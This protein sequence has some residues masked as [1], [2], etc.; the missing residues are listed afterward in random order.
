MLRG[1][2]G[3]R[4][5]R[6]GHEDVVEH[7]RRQI[8]VGEVAVVLRLLLAA[9]AEG[10]PVVLVP[11]AGLLH[12]ASAGVENRG[13]PC[14]L[15]RDGFLD[16]AERVDVLQLDARAELRLAQGADAHVRVAP[17]ASLLEVAVVDADEDEDVAQHTQVLRGF[18]RAAQIGLA[19]DLD[20]RY[21]GAVE[22]DHARVPAV[23][24]LACVLL[25]V[26][27]RDADGADGRPP[28]SMSRCP[29]SL[30]GSSYWLIWYPFG[31]SG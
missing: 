16:E 14:D 26:D 20:E 24:A 15:V 29:R 8:R 18:R 13:L 5:D 6:L 30:N 19:D 4:R 11:A 25:H 10:R 27:A 9:E 22:V 21:A 23:R 3:K 28:I 1:S 2:S 12:D 31:R 17:E 7:E